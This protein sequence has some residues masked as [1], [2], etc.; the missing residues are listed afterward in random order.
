MNN[1]SDFNVIRTL[2]NET[3]VGV[4][5]QPKLAVCGLVWLLDKLKLTRNLPI[6]V[7]G[8]CLC[9]MLHV[10]HILKVE[11]EK[12]VLDIVKNIHLFHAHCKNEY[13]RRKIFTSCLANVTEGIHSFSILSMLRTI[14]SNVFLYAS[15]FT[16]FIFRNK[17]T[18]H[19]W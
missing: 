9:L 17:R 18:Q 2:S 11:L 15:L 4:G 14:S 13:D 6:I 12:K 1:E 8:Q 7:E 10:F 3:F 19:T 5:C 16:L